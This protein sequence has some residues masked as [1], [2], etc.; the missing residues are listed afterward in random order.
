MNNIINYSNISS[1]YVP[2]F[3]SP[4]EETITTKILNNLWTYCWLTRIFNFT[5]LQKIAGHCTV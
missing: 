2:H 1:K 3:I 4:D 5:H